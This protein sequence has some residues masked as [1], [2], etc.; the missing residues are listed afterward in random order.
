MDWQPLFE[1]L[2]DDKDEA[3]QLNAVSQL[4]PHAGN[5]LVFEKLCGVALKTLNSS[6]RNRII[7]ALIPQTDRACRRFCQAASS[8]TCADTHRWAL[9]N[10]SLLNCRTP[11]SENAIH[12]GLNHPNFEINK[13]AALSIG[14]FNTPDFLLDV[15][16]FMERNRFN[17]TQD[18]LRTMAFKIADFMRKY[19]RRGQQEIK[20][21][22]RQPVIEI[23]C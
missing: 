18:N 1:Q 4:T 20:S 15:E 10:L 16:R 12:K 11:E 9:V 5:F 22:K 21:P 19:S 13:A 7:G 8:A 6:V 14:L 3:S 23:S 2:H 17:F